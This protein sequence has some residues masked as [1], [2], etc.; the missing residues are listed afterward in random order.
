MVIPALSKKLECTIT[1]THVKTLA[2]VKPTVR[3]IISFFI[4]KLIGPD[5]YTSLLE[6]LSNGVFCLSSSK[7]LLH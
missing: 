3:S 4:Y 6:A 1:S 7:M 2:L 5:E